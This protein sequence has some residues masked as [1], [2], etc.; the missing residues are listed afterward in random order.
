MT[1]VELG[2]QPQTNPM[3]R[4]RVAGCYRLLARIGHGR[5]GDIFEAVDEGHHDLGVE[6]R[7]AVQLLPDR[8]PRN[9]GLFN[10]LNLGYTVLRNAP[11]PNIVRILDFDRDEQFGYLV[12]EY[13]DGASLRLILD[14][15]GTLSLDEVL[16]VIRAVGDALQFL[17]ANS[18]VHGRLNAENVFITDN[19]EIRLLDVVPLDSTTTIFRGVASGDPF[20]RCE[21]AEDLYSLA[22]LAYE[23]L[24]GKHPF[25]F[26]P[27]DEARH[28]GLEPAR[29]DSLSEK[30]WDA[31]RR[32]MSPDPEQQVPEIKE[33]LRDF[34]IKGTERLQRDEDTTATPH[35]PKSSNGG[36]IPVAT[37]P[38]TRTGPVVR[39]RDAL[40]VSRA[41]G[42]R[43]RRIPSPI[44]MLALAG[45]GAWHFFGQPHDDVIALID[46]VEASIAAR[47]LPRDDVGLTIIPSDLGQAAAVEMETASDVSVDATQTADV[48]EAETPA[49]SVAAEADASPSNEE[50]AI[51]ELSPASA[52]EAS[53]RPETRTT[54][55]RSV[56]YVSERDGAARIA[57]RHPGNTAAQLFWWTGDHTAVAEYDYI[58]IVEPVEAFTSGEEAETVHIP[59][60]N[61]SMPEPVETFY[62]YLGQFDAQSEQLEPVLRVRVEINDDD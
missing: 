45:L 48:S 43:A 55:I 32:A 59:L 29:I 10:K 1:T 44:L 14:N 15:S 12:M 23:M 36:S 37:T 27:L 21:I 53:S 61:D 26:H 20:S 39:Q 9:N 17:H 3:G 16:P 60:V 47:S 41:K 46:Y 54:L 6:Y 31:L 19:L 49:E 24:A 51:D 11:H 56:V 4:Q 13:L 35:P 40:E 8:V 57:T 50:N 34:E 18:V 7:V 58:P 38:A 33:F 25:N 2:H 62:V 42:K 52:I 28:A 30:Q 5:L 22:C